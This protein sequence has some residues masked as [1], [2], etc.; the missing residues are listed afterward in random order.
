MNPRGLL[1]WTSRSSQLRAPQSGIFPDAASQELFR[2]VPVNPIQLVI[3]LLRKYVGTI[4][5]CL[6]VSTSLIL[7][8]A[9]R[10][11]RLYRATANI[12]IYRESEGAVPVIK[13]FG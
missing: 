2:A 3:R 7:L 9:A 4:I 1:K 8:Y 13:S 5:I 10:Q 12:A 11:P 6:A